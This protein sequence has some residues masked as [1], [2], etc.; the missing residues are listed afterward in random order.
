[1][2]EKTVVIWDQCGENP[3][4][5][6][7]CAGNLAHL[8]NTYVNG[9]DSTEENQDLIQ[10]AIDEG[11]RHEEFPLELIQ[12]PEAEIVAVICAGVIP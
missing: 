10:Q 4:E 6:Y 1:M 8:N 3:L 11:E 2:S 5:F 9:G 7:V 12:D